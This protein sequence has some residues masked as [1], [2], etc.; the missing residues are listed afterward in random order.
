MRVERHRVAAS[1]NG[2]WKP[3]WAF[4][5]VFRKLI[6]HDISRVL[7]PVS[8]TA[9]MSFFTPISSYGPQK[10]SLPQNLIRVLCFNKTSLT[11]KLTPKALNSVSGP[12]HS[13]ELK[14]FCD[15]G[16]TKWLSCWWVE[17]L[18]SSPFFG[19]R[20]FFCRG[21]PWQTCLTKSCTIIG[22]RGKK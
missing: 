15:H 2:G 17:I 4:C 19:H 16:Y 14:K 12:H 21:K 6:F 5:P 22:C 7:G 8:T 11:K 3:H 10:S 20:E 18:L 9:H 1:Q 13:Y